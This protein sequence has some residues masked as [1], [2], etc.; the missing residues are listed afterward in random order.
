M[1]PDKLLRLFEEYPE[2]KAK[3][4][5]RVRQQIE[6]NRK[7]M[8]VEIRELLT[9]VPAFR[10]GACT[11]HTLE[12]V[13]GLIFK[14]LKENAKP[15]MAKRLTAAIDEDQ[16]AYEQCVQAV[17]QQMIDQE[18]PSSQKIIEMFE[19]AFKGQDQD[20]NNYG[21]MDT[22]NLWRHVFGY[23]VEDALEEFQKHPLGE[24]NMKRIFAK[25]GGTA[26]V[27]LPPKTKEDQY[28]NTVEDL[29]LTA[30]NGHETYK[31]CIKEVQKLMY[32]HKRKLPADRVKYLIKEGNTLLIQSSSVPQLARAW[33]KIFD[34]LIEPAIYELESDYLCSEEELNV[35]K[36]FY[37]P[38]Q[39]REQLGKEI[40]QHITNAQDRFDTVETKLEEIAMSNNLKDTPVKR[41]TYIYGNDI[42][43]LTAANCIA[44]IKS[45]KKQMEDL[46]KMGV[47]SK[48]IKGQLLEL[49]AVLGLLITRMDTFK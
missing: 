19:L 23:L 25:Y 6:T 37:M 16:K 29:Y 32:N 8:L 10:T 1:N 40:D 26:K 15:S 24:A 35:I 9:P 39:Y 31:R 36:K 48:Y 14:E 2:V 22:T 34:H 5:V 7:P 30:V 13:W 4:L 17:C 21:M 43:E 27:H 45:V 12:T 47:E 33:L 18:P 41:V 44:V 49:N 38:E 46:Q 3:C 20:F 28:D 42:E 11:Q